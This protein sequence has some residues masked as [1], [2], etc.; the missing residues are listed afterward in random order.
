MLG[1][2]KKTKPEVK[3]LQLAAAAAK[4][5]FHSPLSRVFRRTQSII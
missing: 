3:S 2:G 1:T 4:K 5:V